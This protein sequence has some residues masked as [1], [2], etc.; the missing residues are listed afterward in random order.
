ME[1]IKSYLNTNKTKIAVVVIALIAAIFCCTTGAQLLKNAKTGEELKVSQST[2][3]YNVVGTEKMVSDTTVQSGTVTVKYLDE[4][5]NPILNQEGEAIESTVKTGNVGD[6]YEVSRPDFTGYVSAKDEPITRAGVY[7]L[8]NID[9]NFIYKK[10]VGE[11]RTK[12]ENEGEDNATEN[13]IKVAFNNSR[14]KRDYA[15]KIITKDE[16]ENVISGGQFSINKDEE[17]LREGKVREG[18]FYVGKIAISTE[19]KTIYEIDQ[20]KATIGYRKIEDTIDL[21]ITST[22]NNTD[23]KFEITVD[24]P[25]QT[26]VKISV[27]EQD[28]IIIEVTNEKI[29]N[30][31]EVEIINK[32]KNTLITGT[33]FKVNK[34]EE[35]Q[36]DDYTKNGSLY[37]GAY[38]VTEDGV[39]RYTIYETETQEGY[40]QAIDNETP[41]I[42]EVVKKF[43]EEKSQYDITVRHNGLPGL[44]AEVEGNSKVTIYIESEKIDDP[45]YDLVIKKFVSA[46]DDE[47]IINREPEVKIVEEENEKTGTTVKKVEYTQE[48]EIAKTANEQKVTYTVRTYNESNEIATGKRIIEY[49]PDG[50]IYLPENETNTEYGWKPYTEDEDGDLIEAMSIEEAT[51]VATD[52]LVEKEIEPF[53]IEKEETPK[54][55]DIKIVFEVDES[56][57]TSE[58]RIIE[59]KVKIQ[60]NEY[61]ETRWN[62]E[63]TEKIYVKYFDL[64]LT[65]YIKE[66]TVKNNIKE[67]K[68]EIGES[69]KGKLV[70]IDVAKNEVNNTTIRVTYGLK[71][72]NIGEI[73][74]YATEVIDYI[75]EDFE[76]VN[77]G[78]WKINGNT[79]VTT[80][81]ENKLLKPGESTVIEITF[82][83]KLTDSNIGRR[84]NEGKITKY[85]NPY[86]AKDPTED[87]NDKEEMLVQVR[88]GSTWVF[89]TIIVLVALWMF[90]GIVFILKRKNETEE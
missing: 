57:L 40:Y 38:E 17:K 8:G 20:T 19:E 81:L 54:Y 28:E 90:A 46:I 53:D 63:T 2:E 16:N 76:L 74:G 56:K 83:W 89:V 50:L 47:E 21:G 52:Y 41:V 75:P 69:Q 30:M 77:D 32:N 3:N 22:W 34:G 42:I 66:V 62:D 18:I 88:T 6:E 79:A 13:Q 39:E 49:I 43:N 67:T 14:I 27:T 1:K 15:I 64:D 78:N 86:N 60:P 37:V 12:V 11:V 10:A 73:E 68:Q 44:S 35:T 48:N 29:E 23:K 5:G 25:T 31:Y 24:E 59:N 55:L 85:E 58:D 36:V 45:K 72:K 51:I 70:K 82:D 33:K 80:K 9:V 84:I 7:E 61:D 4:K 87:N 71:V 26:N 65:K